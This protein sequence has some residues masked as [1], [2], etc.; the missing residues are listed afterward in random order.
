L[1]C[2]IILEGWP[3]KTEEILEKI[4][5]KWNWIVDIERLQRAV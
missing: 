4:S 3:N 1:F 5:K 2:E